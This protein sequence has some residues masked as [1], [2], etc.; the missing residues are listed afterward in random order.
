MDAVN[1][2][3]PWVEQIK[4]QR[5]AKDTKHKKHN[6]YQNTQVSAS[7]AESEVIEVEY[8]EKVVLATDTK[9]TERRTGSERRLSAKERGRWLESREQKE[10]RT[11]IAIRLEI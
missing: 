1:R 6:K 9:I 5:A 4:S 11:P 7:S 2:V 3:L 8:D 10:R